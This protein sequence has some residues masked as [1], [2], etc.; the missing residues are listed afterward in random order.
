M[1]DVGEA[2]GLG[3]KGEDHSEVIRPTFVAGVVDKGGDAAKERD[4]EGGD[5]AEER[6][7]EGGDVAE[8]RDGES[9]VVLGRES[10]ACDG[11]LFGVVGG[12]GGA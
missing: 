2:V 8:E 12:W 7:G 11:N 3:T 4:G 6:D 10:E 5:A 9:C 1:E